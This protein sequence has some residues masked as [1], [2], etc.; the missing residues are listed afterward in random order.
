[1]SGEPYISCRSLKKS[2]GTHTVLEDLDLDIYRGETIVILGH[3]GTGKSVLLKHI[4]ALLLPDKG[5]VIFAGRDLTALSEAELATVRREMGMLFQGAALFDSLTVEENVAFA[6]HY[7][8]IGQPEERSHRVAELLEVVGLAGTQEKMPSDLSGGMRKRAALARA[9]ALEPQVLLYDEPT[10]GLDPVTGR[11][12][13][14]LIRNCQ[15]RLAVTSI[16][17]T[18]DLASAYFVADRIAFLYD[19][20]IYRV[21]SVEE[22]RSSGVPVIEEFLSAASLQPR[23][24]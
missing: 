2:F 18:H 11:Q 7:H 10:T 4:N 9:L 17:V 13:N 1:M 19:R 3:S 16:V 6:L 14:E 15:Q 23:T 20:R 8:G 24:R 12:I 5:Q 21:G 22:M